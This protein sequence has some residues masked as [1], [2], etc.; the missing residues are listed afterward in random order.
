[1]SYPA[2]STVEIRHNTNE[3]FRKAD[4]DWSPQLFTVFGKQA[5]NARYTNPGT[6][7]AGSPLRA[8]YDANTAAQ[9]AWADAHGLN[10]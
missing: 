9:K 8:L 5:C 10:R 2:W 3:A 7:E 4:D 1:M 6:G